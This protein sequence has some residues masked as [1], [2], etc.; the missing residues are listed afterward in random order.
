MRQCCKKRRWQA[1]EG[2][3]A[4]G[5]VGAGKRT[6]TYTRVHRRDKRIRAYAHTFACQ[7]VCCNPV[8]EN[9]ASKEVPRQIEI[10]ICVHK[11]SSA[12][13]NIHKGMRGVDV[14]SAVALSPLWNLST[15]WPLSLFVCV[16]LFVCVCP[17]MA[18]STCVYVFVCLLVCLFWKNAAPDGLLLA[19]VFCALM[20]LYVS[21]SPSLFARPPLDV[22][23]L[24]SLPLCLFP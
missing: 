17:L 24:H 9:E 18:L 8:G 13:M 1:G 22:C 3:T 6:S 12:I 14:G 20:I 15:P 11:Y 2:G 16:G 19:T 23:P 5:E 4:A 21:I 7:A 10:F